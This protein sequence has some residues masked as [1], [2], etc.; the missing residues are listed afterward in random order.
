MSWAS[1]WYQTTDTLPAS[2]AAIHGQN[3]LT[4]SV[5]ATVT[6]AD[7]DLP[8]SVVETSMIELAAGV[9]APLQPPVVPAWRSSVSQTR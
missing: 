9:L 2:P 3:T 1:V 8:R 7:Q 4:P 6:G 5:C